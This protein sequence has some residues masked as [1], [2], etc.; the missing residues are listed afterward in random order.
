MPMIIKETMTNNT[1]YTVQEH[2]F[3]GPFKV[4]L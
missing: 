1:M 4:T 3:P 2:S